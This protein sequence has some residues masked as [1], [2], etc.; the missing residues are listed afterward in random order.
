LYIDPEAAQASQPTW[1]FTGQWG[2]RVAGSL[3]EPKS[4]L[5]GSERARVGESVKEVIS[6]PALG[7]F[8]QNVVA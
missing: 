7:Y 8:F 2:T 5:R 6:A 1:G 4:G 3:P